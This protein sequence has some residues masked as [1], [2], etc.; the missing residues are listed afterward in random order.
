VNPYERRKYGS[1]IVAAMRYGISLSFP[2][3]L[4]SFSFFLAMNLGPFRA[5]PQAGPQCGR[6]DWVYL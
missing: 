5:G 3:F 1:G 4:P 6:S 2:F